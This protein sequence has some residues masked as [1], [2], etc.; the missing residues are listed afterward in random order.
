MS[1][2]GFAAVGFV[3]AVS[4]CASPAKLARQSNEALAKGDL[5]TAYDRALRAVEKDPQNQD[6][7]AA[8]TAASGRVAVDY[9]ARVVA[10][11]SA[12]TV[13]AANLALDYRRFQLEVARHQTALDPAPEYLGAERAILTGAARLHYQRGVDAMALRRPKEAVGEFTA[14]RRYNESYADVVSRLAA[15][16][17]AA[18]VRVALLPFID[19]IRVPGLSQEIADT[20]Q[21]ELS[22]RAVNEFRFTQIVSPG[23]IERSMTVAELRNPRV[24]DAAE[25][26]RRIG[27][28]WI[29]VGRFRGLRASDSRREAKIEIYHSVDRKDGAGV[30]HTAWEAEQL[31]IVTRRREVTVQFELDVVDVATGAVLAHR[32]QSVQAVA[33]VAWTD[34][35]A[36]EH[37]DHYALLSPDDRRNDPKRARAVDAKWREEVGSWDLKDFL[38]RSRE[39]RDRSRYT[40]R[41]RGE[42]YVDTRETPAWM[43]ELPSE[44]DMAFVALKDVWRD[45]HAALKEL[46]AKD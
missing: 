12:D 28:D 8:Y 4:S 11:A 22:R 6:A 24:E 3:F 35:R 18:T 36:E 39:G 38:R 31:P 33:R 37:F 20:V 13:Q 30:V 26:G 9:R 25:L 7:R 19:G 5:R 34:F 14:A 17:R 41:Y 45:V 42:F 44:N 43:G 29:V 40:S 46:D 27:A 10:T 23:E 2:R 15:A 21:R 32:E 1:V 16:R